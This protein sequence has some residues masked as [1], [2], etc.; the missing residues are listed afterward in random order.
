MLRNCKVRIAGLI[1]LAALAM[2]G[3]RLTAGGPSIEE[4]RTGLYKA[5]DAG[6]WKDAYDGLRKLALDTK[7]DPMKVGKDLS[8]AILCLQRL[9]RVAEA[10]AFREAVIETHKDN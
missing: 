3:W 1:A 2:V 4:K 5:I 8:Q 7:N 6:N 9:G 10:D